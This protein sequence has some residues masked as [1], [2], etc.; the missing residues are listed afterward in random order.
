MNKDIFKSFNYSLCTNYKENVIHDI[1]CDM[2]RDAMDFELDP[3]QLLS[4]LVITEDDQN[5]PEMSEKE[6][7]L[8]ST[9]LDKTIES[10]KNVIDY[11]TIIELLKII[12][13]KRVSYEENISV[14]LN[15]ASKFYFVDGFDLEVLKKMLFAGDN[16]F[17]EEIYKKDGGLLDF[18]YTRLAN[19]SLMK[20]NNLDLFDEYMMARKIYLNEK[21]KEKA[22]DNTLETVKKSQYY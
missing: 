3:N 18:Y 11:Q 12:D 1:V 19:E 15:L 7:N 13:K 5:K 16:E 22:L 6:L 9:I 4:L 10:E 21:K 14:C 2:F 17:D 20:D 8:F